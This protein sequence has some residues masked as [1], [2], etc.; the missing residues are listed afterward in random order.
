MHFR[1]DLFGEHAIEKVSEKEVEKRGITVQNRE[2]PFFGLSSKEILIVEIAVI[3]VALAFI[4][5]DRA[6]LT[7][8][9]RTG[10]YAR[11]RESL[12]LVMI[13]RT[14]ILRP[15]TVTMLIHSSGGWAPCIMFLT[16]WLYGNAFAQ[17]YRN[18]IKRE[19]NVDSHKLGH[20]NGCR[21]LR[22]YYS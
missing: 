14:G 12:L 8:E 7:L 22:K 11:W 9:N 13:S 10:L 6:D 3:I 1:L 5:A 4:L 20:R 18:L 17:S 15:K 21:S 16:A 19:E 2:R